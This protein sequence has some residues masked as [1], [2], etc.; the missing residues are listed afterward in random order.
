MSQLPSDASL[1]PLPPLS[2]QLAALLPRALRATLRDA[3]QHPARLLALGVL[4]C[5]FGALFSRL[6]RDTAGAV[7]TALSVWWMALVLLGLVVFSTALP[8]AFAGRAVAAREATA[9]RMYAPGVAA[10][11]ALAADAPWVAAS[12]SLAAGIIAPLVAGGEG[13]SVAVAGAFGPFWAASVLLTLALGA[14]LFGL[15]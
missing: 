14:K 13:G 3:S 11:A 15:Y 8:S 4:S 9:S 1:P 10:L 6:P 2:A 12:A 5:F 7:E